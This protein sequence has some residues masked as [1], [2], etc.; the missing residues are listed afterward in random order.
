MLYVINSLLSFCWWKPI[1]KILEL[2]TPGVNPGLQR[3]RPA[4]LPL[5]HS[6][7]YLTSVN[8]VLG[9][10]SLKRARKIKDKKKN[11]LTWSWSICVDY[12]TNTLSPSVVSVVI[13]SSWTPII[14]AV[15]D[16][17]T[18]TKTSCLVNERKHTSFSPS[19]SACRWI[20]CN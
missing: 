19:V 6:A 14:T 5:D 8:P 10:H 7:A 18:L 9:Q 13:F 2:P 15:V 4:F 12:L 17:C 16:R 20:C 1:L 3:S 11:K